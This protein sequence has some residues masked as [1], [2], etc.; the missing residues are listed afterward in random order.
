MEGINF[1]Y[2]NVTKKQM[3]NIVK[4]YKDSIKF[5]KA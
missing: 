1:K 5:L 2:P 3:L 4:P